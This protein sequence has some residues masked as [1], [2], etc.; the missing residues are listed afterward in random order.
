MTQHFL[1]PLP[2]PTPS[3]SACS[4]PHARTPRLRACFHCASLRHHLLPLPSHL[5]CRRPSFA[6]R[7]TNHLT[8]L[9]S[10]CRTVMGGMAATYVR[11]LEH[12][13]TVCCAAC[14][15]VGHAR[16][17]TFYYDTHFT[18]FCLFHTA[19]KALQGLY[20]TGT[21]T[22]RIP[23]IRRC[24]RAPGTAFAAWTMSLHGMDTANTR[25]R[26]RR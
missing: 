16:P 1:L 11:I 3:R 2:A 22:Y 4:L 18:R 7:T 25:T 9:Q 26:W 21:V 10:G 6:R 24:P 14:L 13:W 20:S 15:L 17:V 5:C 8:G 12:S 23:I 19:G